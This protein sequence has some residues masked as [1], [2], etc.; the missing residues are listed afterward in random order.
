MYMRRLLYAICLPVMM[1]LSLSATAQDKVITGRVLDTA[2]RGIPGVSV[3][4]KGQ[5]SR[6][7]TTSDGGSYS[8]SVPSSATTLIFSSVGYGSREV[9]I[10]SRGTAEVTLQP[11]SGNLS[12]VVVIGYGTARKRDL[13][14]SVTA[15]S[16]KDFNKGAITTP[17][18]LIVGKVAGVQITTN[19]GAPGSGSTIRIRG[20][21]SLSA[22]NDP[23]IVV[24]G[25][26]LDNS[27]ISGAPNGLALINPAYIETFNI[28]KDASATAIY[29]SRASNGVIIITTKKGKSGKTR[30][31]FSSQNSL[32]TLPKKADV[33]T[34][35]EL[36]S[37]VKAHGTAS[38][39]ALLGTAKTDW[40]SQVF[41]R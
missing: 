4:I 17:E 40:Q 20:G 25:V 26:P 21:A 34:G 2:G 18:Q 29:G 14:G 28:L 39:I 19:G 37:F 8:L 11:T 1:F 6:G 33:L 24:D 35:D 15:I 7:T 5:G 22:S 30:F 36:R 16:A 31:N 32:S 41:Q 9:S 23:L 3:S 27:G 38:Q 13:T 10:T 12:E